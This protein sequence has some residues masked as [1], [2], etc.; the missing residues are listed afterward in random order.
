MHVQGRRQPGVAVVMHDLEGPSRPGRIEA[1]GH[2][3]ANEGGVGL[4]EAALEADGAVL[5][6]PASRLEQ[7]EVVEVEP[8]TGMADVS[9]GG[10]PPV[11]RRHAAEAAMGAHV[12]LALDPGVEPAVQGLEVAGVPVLEPRQDAAPDGPEEPLD[13]S[14]P[15][16]VV[17]PRVDQDDAELRAD[18]RQV[19]GAEARTV[20]DVEP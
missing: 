10:G 16:G 19:P 20:V 4:V 18:E 17:R 9:G 7:E 5:G 15:G 2:G 14:L 8:G 12:V 13:L 6:D 1:Q 11:E 3:L